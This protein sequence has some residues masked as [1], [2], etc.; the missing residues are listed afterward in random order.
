MG[1]SSC[2]NDWGCQDIAGDS[3][4]ESTLRKLWYWTVID[5]RYVLWSDDTGRFFGFAFKDQ[6]SFDQ[7]LLIWWTLKDNGCCWIN[8]WREF[9]QR[10]KAFGLASRF[11]VVVTKGL[12]FCWEIWPEY[13]HKRDFS[14]FFWWL[15]SE[16]ENKCHS[17]AWKSF[18]W[19]WLEAGANLSIISESQLW[20]GIACD[21]Y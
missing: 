18:P 15:R 19:S 8:Y 20:F 9:S 11:R 14:L 4:V 1:V 16:R 5:R 12:F 7:T 2:R 10:A 3:E 13:F 6:R 21:S 17:P